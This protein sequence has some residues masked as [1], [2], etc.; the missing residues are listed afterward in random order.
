MSKVLVFED[1]RIIQ[2]MAEVR[3]HPKL[4]ERVAHAIRQGENM[5][6]VAFSLQPGDE[7]P[8]IGDFGQLIGFL[9][10]EV[11]ILMDGTYTHEDVCGVSEAIRKKLVEKRQ[12][13]LELKS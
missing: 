5:I 8:T 11:G 13:L 7:I 2:L 1:E 10:A 12:P 9:A 3:R 4:L 6:E